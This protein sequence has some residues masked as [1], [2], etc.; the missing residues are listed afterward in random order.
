MACLPSEGRY[1]TAGRS[2]GRYATELNRGN[3]HPGR[4]PIHRWTEHPMDGIIRPIDVYR[5]HGGVRVWHRGVV[6]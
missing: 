4:F 1:A 6:R 2:E 3:Y 5:S